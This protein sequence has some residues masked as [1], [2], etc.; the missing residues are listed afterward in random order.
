MTDTLPHLGWFVNTKLEVIGNVLPDSMFAGM[1]RRIE[2][3]V[4][5]ALV[6]TY[7]PIRAILGHIPTYLFGAT[8]NLIPQLLMLLLKGEFG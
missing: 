8:D 5:W 2:A 7:D 1:A 6:T 4:I 3:L